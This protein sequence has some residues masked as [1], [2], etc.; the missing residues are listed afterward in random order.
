M[1][2]AYEASSS[3]GILGLSYDNN[4]W[5]SLGSNECPFRNYQHSLVDS[6]ITQS[7]AF[8]LYLNST[9]ESSQG[10]LIFGGVGSNLYTGDLYTI[11]M[12]GMESPGSTLDSIT[13]E[14]NTIPVKQLALLDTNPIYLP[15]AILLPILK[16]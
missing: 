7:S 12:T 8:F 9:D 14:R 15:S 11:P 3:Y 6:G 4:Y 5:A 10:S 13:F 16:Y 1:G 2:L